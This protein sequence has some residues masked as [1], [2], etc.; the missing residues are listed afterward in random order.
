MTRSSLISATIMSLI[1][2][3]LGLRFGA[4]AHARR[5]IASGI[6]YALDHL[7]DTSIM[8]DPFTSTAWLCALLSFSLAWSIWAIWCANPQPERQGEEHGSARWATKKEV[9]AFANDKEPDQNFL[10]M[11][12]V[13]MAC[14]RERFDLVH[15]R[16]LNFLVV[17]GSG[18]GKTRYVVKPNLMQLYGDY[19]IIDPKGTLLAECGHLFADNGY[20]IACLNTVDFE[21]SDHVNP[22]RYVKTDAEILSFAN[23]WIKNTNG[24]KDSSS[25]DPFWEK[26][27]TL[28]YVSL[29]ALMRDWFPARDF[30]LP[31]LSYLLSLAEAQEDNEAYESPLDLLFKQIETG[32][33]CEEASES[34][35]STYDER[36]RGLRASSG[37]T[38]TKEVPSSFVRRDGVCPYQ[39]GGLDP[40]EDFALSNYKAFKAAAGKTLKSI[41]ISCNVRMKPIEIRE[42]ARILA[43]PIGEDGEPTGECDLALDQLGDPDRKRAIFLVQSDTDKTFSFLLAVLTWQAI[44]VCCNNALLRYGGKLP[45]LVQFMLDEFAN[46]GTLPD[47]EQTIAVT[48]SRN[49][50]LVVILQSIAQLANNYTEEA[51]KIIQGNCDTQLFLGA[52]DHETNK[53]VSEMI[54]QQ[55]IRVRTHNETRGQSGSTT[56][57]YQTQARALIDPAEVGLVPKDKAI[58]LIKGA[59]PYMG[60]KYM[61][62]E[63]PRYACIDP[64]HAPYKRTPALHAE[65]YRTRA[66]R[67]GRG[68][69]EQI[70]REGRAS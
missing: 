29:I 65:P 47:I 64:G 34:A 50:S 66:S 62:E 61:L 6:D 18:S 53:D 55:T 41:I 70:M 45:R 21:S 44:N 17:G 11:R 57:N 58:V 13:A 27:E 3:A 7:F 24:K 68:S 60:R 54:G 63:H 26:A 37:P 35:Q 2:G 49:V 9:R 69:Q 22:L 42:L 36:S 56:R 12:D 16:N 39:E 4:L 8:P 43:G 51:A 31:N 46:V 33:A 28:L 23:A 40:S 25:G 32:M 38:T 14:R 52:A 30:T 59:R 1:A 5:D 15:D 48:R 67:E 19:I 10:L 20:D